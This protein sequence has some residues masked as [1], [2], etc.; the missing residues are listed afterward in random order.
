MLA[1]ACYLAPLPVLARVPY[2]NHGDPY[3]G[4]TELAY[5]LIPLT[6][7]VMCLPSLISMILTFLQKTSWSLRASVLMN[8]LYMASSFAL[9]ISLI[10]RNHSFPHDVK[11]Y[12]Q[13]LLV[14]ETFS[15]A[16]LITACIGYYYHRAGRGHGA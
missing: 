4:Y 2:S 13:D 1:M 12:W 7:I 15:Y 14:F 10:H 9:F 11:G 3:A 16:L 8:I 5:I 6:Y